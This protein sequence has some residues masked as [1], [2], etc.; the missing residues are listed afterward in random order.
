MIKTWRSTKI[1]QWAETGPWVACRCLLDWIVWWM[2]ENLPMLWWG[3]LALCSSWGKQLQVMLGGENEL[4]LPTSFHSGKLPSFP[5]ACYAWSYWAEERQQHCFFEGSEECRV[6]KP[7]R[8]LKG[9]STAGLGEG[10]EERRTKTHVLGHHTSEGIYWELPHP[11]PTNH[12][13]GTI[14]SKDFVIQSHISLLNCPCHLS[15]LKIELHTFLVQFP[16]CL[17][18]ARLVRRYTWRVSRHSFC[19]AIARMG[20]L[21][22]ADLHLVKHWGEIPVVSGS[23]WEKHGQSSVHA[24]ERSLPMPPHALDRSIKLNPLW[25]GKV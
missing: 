15:H 5:S 1:W 4:V 12:L 16:M 8:V 25:G 9:T 10:K 13:C 20:F 22:A 19:W 21:E 7:E 17:K 24:L 3:G 18:W 6:G 2:K 23:C 14:Q 11:L